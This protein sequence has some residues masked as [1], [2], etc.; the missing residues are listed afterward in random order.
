MQNIPCTKA[1]DEYTKDIT[2]S[3]WYMVDKVD[4]LNSVWVV[5][6]SVH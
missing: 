2:I 4:F 1:S 5:V 6:N 3:S